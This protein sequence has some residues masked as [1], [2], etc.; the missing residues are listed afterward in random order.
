MIGMGKTKKERRVVC[1]FKAIMIQIADKLLPLLKQSLLL[2]KEQ[3]PNTLICIH[4]SCNLAN[5]I[6]SIAP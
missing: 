2:W 4:G 1:R 6:G 3:G 5:V